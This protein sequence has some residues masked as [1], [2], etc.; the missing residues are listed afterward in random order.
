[1]GTI[2]GNMFVTLQILL[3]P[4]TC[5]NYDL[6]ACVEIEQ[7]GY[8]TNTWHLTPIG[9]ILTHNYTRPSIYG[10]FYYFVFCFFVHIDNIRLYVLIS[11]THKNYLF[12]N[13]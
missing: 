7:L 9:P 6:K 11:I 5:K 1:M 12:E 2:Y 8:L 13:I 4:P 10:R 3:S